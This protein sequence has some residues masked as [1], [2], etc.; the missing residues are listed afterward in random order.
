MLTTENEKSQWS[1]EVFITWDTKLK[2][3][4]LFF[5]TTTVM[6]QYVRTIAKKKGH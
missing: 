1:V 5:V 3:N 6:G 2:N 4:N